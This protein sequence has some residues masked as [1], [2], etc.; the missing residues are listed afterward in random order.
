MYE[1]AILPV[2]IQHFPNVMIFYGPK[3]SQLIKTPIDNENNR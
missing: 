2:G 1:D 3:T